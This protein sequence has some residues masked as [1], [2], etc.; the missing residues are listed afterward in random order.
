MRSLIL[1]L[2]FLTV[3]PVPG[4]EAQGPVALGRAAWWFPVVGLVLGAGLAGLLHGLEG[5]FSP[6]V[7]AVLSAVAIAATLIPARRAMR[8]NPT[9]VLRS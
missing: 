7:A 5:L 9:E 4:P 2:R 3:L 6:L 8:V 1:A